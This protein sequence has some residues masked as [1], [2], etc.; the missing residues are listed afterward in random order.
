MRFGVMVVAVILLL[1][2]SFL[3]V[4]KPTDHI[5]KQSAKAV[6]M[7]GGER[8]AMDEPKM[9]RQNNRVLAVEEFRRS[10]CA[11]GGDSCG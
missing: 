3:S 2:L 7:A 9:E 5:A 1:G 6:M 10:T 11:G 4:Q 8:L